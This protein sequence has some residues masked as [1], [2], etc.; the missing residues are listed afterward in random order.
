MGVCGWRDG[1]C[2][3][4]IQYWW[5]DGSWMRTMMANH[6][7]GTWHMKNDNIFLLN[8]AV[9]SMCTIYPFCFDLKQRS[10]SWP[11]TRKRSHIHTHAIK[12]TNHRLCWWQLSTLCAAIIHLIRQLAIELYAYSF[13]TMSAYV[14]WH[15]CTKLRTGYRT[16]TNITHSRKTV[17]GYRRIAQ[18]DDEHDRNYSTRTD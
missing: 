11:L 15:T 4:C 5:P 9:V 7:S 13:W 16:G 12:H 8:Y 6:F 14:T 18:T 2:A 1:R 3:N 10:N 17:A